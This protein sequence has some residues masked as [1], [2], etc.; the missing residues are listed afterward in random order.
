[1]IVT[2]SPSPA[3]DWTIELDHLVEGG[4]NR[5]VSKSREASGKGVN[6]SWALHK[7][8]VETLTVFPSGG[9]TGEFIV[10]TLTT[11]GIPVEVVETDGGVRINVTL[12]VKG[13]GDT[14]INTESAPL[15]SEAATQLRELVSEKLHPGDVLVSCGSLP[16]GAPVDLHRHI[17]EQGHARGTTC[18]LDTSGSALES[19][20]LAKP[21]IIKPNAAELAELV[22]CELTALG[23]VESACQKLISSGLGAVLVSLGE[24]GALYVDSGVSIHGT[25]SNVVARNTVGAGDALLAGFLAGRFARNL[26]VG[27]S[28]GTGLLWA[29]SS[30]ESPS[31]LFDVNP[32]HQSSISLSDSFNRGQLLSTA[33]RVQGATR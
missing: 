30:V 7:A 15:S 8:G 6:V 27:A 28:L 19:G 1:M 14:K 9:D 17:I 25:T 4:V 26:E 22:D 24:D 31:T 21:H 10:K 12:T 32:A 11:Q 20:I 29:A 13:R 23:D 3:V 2:V 16:P 18:V 5:G 33:T